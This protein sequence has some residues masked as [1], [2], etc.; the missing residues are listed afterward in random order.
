M[1]LK[2]KIDLYRKILPEERLRLKEMES[3]LQQLKSNNSF[4]SSIRI[5]MP[6]GLQSEHDKL[7][8]WIELYTEKLTQWEMEYYS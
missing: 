3:K 7:R 8:A 6:F 4:Q 5:Y 1:N 2:A